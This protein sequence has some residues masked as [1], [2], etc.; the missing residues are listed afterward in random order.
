M[1]GPEFNSL[2]QRVANAW[3]ETIPDLVLVPSIP[4]SEASQ[5]QFHA[6]L[7]GAAE[8]VRD[9]PDWL[10]LPLQPDDGYEHGEMQNRRPELISAM[11]KVKT[12]IDNWIA[13]LLRMGLCDAVDGQQLRISKQDLK[14]PSNICARLARFGLDLEPGKAET[15]VTCG[16]YPDMFPAW[17]WLAAEADRTA[18]ATGKKGVPPVRFS[19]CLYSDAYPYARDVLLRLA[20]DSPGLPPLVDLMTREG[21]A[22]V[23]NR[24]NRLTA[25][26]VKSYGKT[27]EPLKDAWG[28]RTHGGFSIEYD[29]IRKRPL[30]FAL[31]IPEFKILL[32]HFDA[33]PDRVQAFVVRQTKHC[34]NCGYCTQTDKTGTR[35]PAFVTVKH[36][37]R[38][39]LCLMFP[40][41]AYT[42]QVVDEALASDIQAFLAFVDGTLARPS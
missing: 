25:D 22:L 35:K 20:P 40:G 16:A 21:Y 42:W 29:W 26:W 38:H 19:H 39:P 37:G 12:K 11:R 8:A 15:V 36:D 10:D 6:F 18:P 14:L 1:T 7:R 31:R 30:L 5:R 32:E 3:A 9:H 17:T 23:C 28:E 24:D 33:M 41:F 27:D 2:A 4:V 13:L 34:N